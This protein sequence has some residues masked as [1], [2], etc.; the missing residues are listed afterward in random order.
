MT[1]I[2]EGNTIKFHHFCY[3]TTRCAYEHIHGVSSNL[4][5]LSSSLILTNSIQGLLKNNVKLVVDCLDGLF[6]QCK[7]TFQRFSSYLMKD[8]RISLVNHDPSTVFIISNN[9]NS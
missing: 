7:N 4:T 2:I 1:L 8:E 3:T 5:A 9:H 6:L